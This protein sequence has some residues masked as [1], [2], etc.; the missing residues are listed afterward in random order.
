MYRA[1]SAPYALRPVIEKD[2]ICLEKMGAIEKVKYS[3]W[4]TPIVPVPKPDGTVRV[5]S[6]FKI[7]VNPMLHVDQHL[8]SKAEDLFA[9]LAGGKKFQNWTFPRHTNKYCC[10]QMTVNIL[11]LTLIWGFFSILACLLAL[12]LLQQFFNK[13]Y[14]K[15]FTWNSKSYMLPG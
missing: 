15:D 10:I 13:L 12:H 3:D 1:G 4:A 14:G 2:L 8:I 5:C 11:L 7:T 9:T 6:D